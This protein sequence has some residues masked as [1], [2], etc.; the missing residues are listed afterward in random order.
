MVDSGARHSSVVFPLPASENSVSVVGFSGVPEQLQFSTIQPCALEG[1]T[2]SHQFL[3]APS[4]PMNLMGRDLLCELKAE[5]LLSKRGTMIKFP[6]GSIHHCSLP[7][8]RPAHSLILTSSPE[9]VSSTAT[10]W[11]GLLPPQ[12]VV[13]DSF[14]EWARWINSLKPYDPPHDPLHCTMNYVHGSDDLYDDLWQTWI[15]PEEVQVRD[16]YV[17]EAGVA[18]AVSLP[19]T[20]QPLYQAESHPHVSLAIAAGQEARALGPMVKSCVD[21]C[22]WTATQ[23]KHLLYSPSLKAFMI[24]HRST[25]MLTPQKELLHRSHGRE[26]SDHPATQAMLDSLPLSLWSSGSADVGLVSCEPVVVNLKP[27]TI[28]IWRPQYSL[29]PEKTL[30]IAGTIQGLLETGVLIPTSSPWNTPILPVPKPGKSDYRMVH[31]LRPINAVVQ[32]SN[33]PTPNPYTMLSNIGPQH[34]FFT[35]IDLANAFFCV[36]LHPDSRPIFTFTYSGQQYTYTRLPQGY[37]DS[38]SLFNHCLKRHLSDLTLPDG[39]ILIQY[40]DDLLIAAQTEEEALI[41]TRDTLLKL[42]S[43]GYKVSRAKLQVARPRVTFLG[44]VISAGHS[45]LTPTHREGILSHSKPQ[46]VREMMSFLGLTGYS[47]HYIPNYVNATLPLRALMRTAGLKNLRARLVWTPEAESA[48]VELKAALSAATHLHPPDYTKPFH[49]D[50]VENQGV[51]NAVLFQKGELGSRSIL[52]YHSSLLDEVEK[53]HPPCTKHIAAIAKALTKTAHITMEGQIIVHTTHGV[54]S[55]LDSKAFTLSH[56][57]TEKIKASLLRPNITFTGEGI[58]AAADMNTTQDHVCAHATLKE[59]MLSENMTTKPIKDPEVV[60]YCDGS[61]YR[62]VNKGENIASYAVVKQEPGPIHTT[63]KSGLMKQPASAQKAEIMGLIQACKYAKDMTVN[64]YTDSAYAHQAVWVDGPHWMRK[65]FVTS[66]GTPIAHLQLILDLCDAVKF[67]KKVAILKCRGHQRVNSLIARGN[68]AADEAAKKAGNY[69]VYKEKMQ[70]QV[71]HDSMMITQETSEL[72]LT[73]ENIVQLQAAASPEERSQW[74]QKGANKTD[75]GLWRNHEGKLVATSK[76]LSM[77][78]Q[79][80]HSRGHC[81]AAKMGGLIS[82]QWWHPNL[83][84]V[85]KYF[86]QSCEICG[87]YNPKKT[88]QAGLGSFPVPA[89]PWKEIVIDFTDMGR[90]QRSQGKRYMLVCV[91]TFSRWVEA[92]PTKT[93]TSQEV[94]KWLV[95]DLIPR[96]GFPSVIRS[97][98]GTHFSSANLREVEQFFGITH[99][100]GSVYHPASQ[101]LVERVNR[102]IKET[103]AKICAG[104][105]MSWVDALPLALMSMRSTPHSSFGVTPHQLLTGRLMPCP[106][107][108]TSDTGHVLLDQNTDITRYAVALANLAQNLSQQV[109]EI[110]TRDPPQPRDE[111]QEGDWVWQKISK[112]HWHQPRWQG[113]FK[114][115]K[116]HSHSVQLEKDGQISNWIHKTHCSKSEPPERTLQ[117]VHSDL[118]QGLIVKS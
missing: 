20:L 8:T 12:A 51:V 48:F 74:L 16:I 28:P 14:H 88:L 11:W 69:F 38:P 19:S 24:T 104:N 72:E 23:N 91:D 57:R 5:I 13:L 102:T 15:D 1:Q 108:A 112:Y 105:G 106:F 31:D 62:D 54:A 77:L 42:A 116:C 97:D 25:V 99:Q 101:G 59:M 55:F 46:T 81:S 63:V 50:V 33:L 82:N 58:N 71:H 93:E 2:F 37:V 35:C 100:F 114:V 47:R 65:G 61:S 4:C 17:G 26:N 118:Q 117:E 49:L 75:S 39:T 95:K 60:L 53:G 86:V 66:T 89:A 43:L 78:C 22:D 30:G 79:E 3:L 56:K 68:A 44:R 27:D 52:M 18:A 107:T 34:K 94:I 109:T 98:N 40:V 84:D 6:N 111:V 90:D 76:L 80:S 110:L 7:S 64:I 103:L 96:Y 83:M 115:V 21:A 9:P 73:E 87:K 45:T 32:P 113:P 67:P 92:V 10:V 41:A 36:P 85:V 29:T 70:S